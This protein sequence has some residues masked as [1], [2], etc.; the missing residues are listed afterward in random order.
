VAVR[1][2]FAQ[3]DVGREHE[4]GKIRA[5]LAKCPLDDPVVRVSA[6][7]LVVLFLGIPKSKITGTPSAERTPA[8]TT[9]SSIE[10]CAIPGSPRA[11]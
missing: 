1:G 9:S 5:Q 7:C 6:G 2:V 3:A 4:I 10:R 11:A 8:S